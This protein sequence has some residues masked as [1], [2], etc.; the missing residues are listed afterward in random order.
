MRGTPEIDCA[1]KGG[2]PGGLPR[3]FVGFALCGESQTSRSG[4]GK[5]RITMMC[6]RDWPT[7]G[8]IG[9]AATAGPQEKP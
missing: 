1:G 4:G 5:F 7:A 8:L 3:A 6:V 9:I 2:P